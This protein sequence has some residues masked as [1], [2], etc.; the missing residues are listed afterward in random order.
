MII[1]ADAVRI[2][3]KVRY[4]PFLCGNV[5]FVVAVALGFCNFSIRFFRRLS[6]QV[7][8]VYQVP[9]LNT[10]KSNRYN[11]AVHS[12]IRSRKADQVFH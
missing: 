5:N 1:S 10:L 7:V 6:D 11:I 8:F 12:Q 2:S 4:P 3:D 9:I